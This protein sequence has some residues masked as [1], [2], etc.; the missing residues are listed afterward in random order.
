MTLQIITCFI[1]AKIISHW[2]Y[3][4]ISTTKRTL[5]WKRHVILIILLCIW[6]W[7]LKFKIRQSLKKLMLYKIPNTLGYTHVY[8][9]G[10]HM[11]LPIRT[12]CNIFGT[13]WK[14]NAVTPGTLHG[15]HSLLDPDTYWQTYV[16]TLNS[17]KR[18]SLGVGGADSGS[19]MYIN[20]SHLCH[21]HSSI[22]TEKKYLDQ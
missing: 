9:R 22:I 3:E 18:V 21:C 6:I 20:S 4:Y 7:Q 11:L 2:K 15:P 17:H 8:F 10:P 12:S 14:I 19:R 13:W 1:T 5:K 16:R